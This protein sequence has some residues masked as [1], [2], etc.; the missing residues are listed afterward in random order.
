[1]NYLLLTHEPAA[2]SAMRNASM[3]VVFQ[4][5][6]WITAGWALLKGVAPYAAIE[7][8][9]PGGSILAI[10]LWLYRKRP[11]RLAAT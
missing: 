2:A 6:R 9:L 10:L 8:L 4:A 7:L 3:P 1:M 11:A 5:A